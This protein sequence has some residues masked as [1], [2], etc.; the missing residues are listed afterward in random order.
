MRRFS[1]FLTICL[2]SVVTLWGQVR[3][4][5]PDQPS[6]VLLVVVDQMR[7]EYLTRFGPEFSGGLKRLIDEGAVFTNANYE[8]APTMTAVGH[9]TILSGA[10]PMLSGIVGNTWYE[11]SEARTVQSITDDAVVPLGGGSGASPRRLAVSMIGDELKLSGKGGK[12]FGVSLKDRGAI[13]PAGRTADGAFWLRAGNFVSSSWYF[14]ALPAWVDD[15]NAARRADEYAGRE[16]LTTSMPDEVGPQLYR[17]LDATPFADEM[18]LELALELLDQEQL[19]GGS[20][21]DLLSVSFS[22]MDYLGHGSGPDTE[23]MHDMVLHV[24]RNIGRLL[25]AAERQAGAGNVLVVLTADHGVAPVPEENVRRN[26]PGGRYDGRAEREAVEQALEGEFGAG[27]YVAASGE[28][29]L[30]L[31]P[32]PVPGTGIDQRDLERVAADALRGQ[33]HVY[34]VYTRTDLESARVSGDRIDQRVLQG[35]HPQRS[36]D[37]LVVHDPNWL[38]GGGGTTHGSPFSY[39][40]HV[41][42]V[43]WGPE[44]LVRRGRFHRDA[45]IHDIAPTLA[46]IL[47]IAQPSGSIGRVLDEMLP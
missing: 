35:F 13:L 14:E 4:T 11:R 16:W 43:F 28:M 42:L 30:Y 45:A 15:F 33:P 27:T 18:V 25:D 22:A 23:L 46:A 31:N 19:G 8:S 41:P 47:G 39:D 5:L 12:V 17:A 6:L 9:S 20:G 1:S 32:D 21:T 2:I 3:S 40:T 37:L 26:L 44:T 7:Y 36:P 29:G 34:R 10:P 38:G 24:D